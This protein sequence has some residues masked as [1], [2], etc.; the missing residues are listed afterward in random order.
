MARQAQRPGFPHVRH[1]DAA[2]TTERSPSPFSINPGR[3]YEV[4]D[5]GR[6]YT[7]EQPGQPEAVGRIRAIRLWWIAAVGA[8][9]VSMGAAAGGYILLGL[10][11]GALLGLLVMATVPLLAVAPLLDWRRQRMARQ[12]HA[13]R[14]RRFGL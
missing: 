12:W 3:L 6:V 4:R 14:P 9:V 10:R 1:H 2:L 11:A 13:A 8:N 5:D 7:E